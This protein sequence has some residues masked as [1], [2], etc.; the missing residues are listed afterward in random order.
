M[1]IDI[2]LEFVTCGFSHVSRKANTLAHNLAEYQCELGEHRFMQG[3]FTP[4][5]CNPDVLSS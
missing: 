2:S 5:I 1:D 3:C 4:S